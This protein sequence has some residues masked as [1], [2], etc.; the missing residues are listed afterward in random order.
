MVHN[1]RKKNTRL[2]AGTTHGWGSMKKHRGAGNRGGRGNAGSGK[3][4]DAKKPS[5]WKIKNF[6]GKHGF[7]SKSRNL[8]VAM[9]ISE[10]NKTIE[11]L[12]KNKK[13]E[14]NGEIYKVN[15]TAL[16]FNKL[17]GTG[18]PDRK[19]HVTVAKASE[20][21]MQKIQAAGGTVEVPQ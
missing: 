4:G 7:T 8:V 5:Y 13:A 6:V 15:L 11:K 3:R 9:N 2:R 10:L 21:A 1:K 16:K 17:L 14:K 19:Y 18:K 12:I 20:K